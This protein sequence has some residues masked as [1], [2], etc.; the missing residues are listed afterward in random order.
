MKRFSGI[1]VLSVLLVCE[2]LTQERNKPVVRFVFYNVENF[3]DIYDDTL[4]NDNDFLPN[5]LMKWDHSRYKNK[6][7]SIYKAIS[8]AGEWD[9]PAVVGFCEVEKKSVLQDLISETYLKKY[10]YGIIH[11]ES[12]DQ[13]GI[14][15][16]LIYRKDLVKLLSYKY[17]KPEELRNKDFRTRSVLYSKMLISGDTIHLF[18][19]HWPSRRGG[20]LAEESLRN[21]I[22]LMVKEKTDS[23]SISVNRQAKI[24]IAGDFNC[25]PGDNVISTLTGKSGNEKSGN[26]ASLVNLSQASAGKGLGTYRYMGMWEMID[27]VIVSEWLLNCRNGLYSDVALF[28]VFNPEFLLCRDPVYPGLIPFSTYRG[29]RYQGGF[30]DHLPVILDLMRR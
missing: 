5:G 6:I 25:T 18:L 17:F 7:T 29:Y 11:E 23:I 9:S 19:N 10:N 22:S 13:R 2:C 3:F 21:G 27:Q 28:R 15:V 16:C 14:D 26:K 30:S 12:G 4:K 8:A 1:L 20:A 24:V